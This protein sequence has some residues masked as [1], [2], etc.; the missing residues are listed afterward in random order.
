[1]HKFLVVINAS[2]PHA[3]TIDFACRLAAFTQNSLT[4]LFVE[5]PYFKSE[6]KLANDEKK[7]QPEVGKLYKK[8]ALATT[9][10]AVA[11]FKKRCHHATVFVTKG[12]PIQEVLR[13]S[14]YADLLI[15]EPGIDFYGEEEPMPSHFTRE[16]LTHSECPVLLAPENSA[17]ME[18]VVFCYDGSASAVFAIKQFTYL[19]PAFKNTSL[20]LLEVIGSGTDEYIDERQQI[21]AWLQAHYKKVEYK[22]LAGKAAD[23]LFTYFFMKEKKLV[24]MGSYGRS[25]LSNFFRQSAADTLIRSVDLPVFITH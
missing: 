14:R 5:N 24:V 1:M 23:E 2:Q 18:E 4:G 3:S 8:T 7:F 20:V 25:A 19:F 6:E 9:D 12:E 13:E 17:E 21:L 15:V 11:L 22:S 10:E 16:M